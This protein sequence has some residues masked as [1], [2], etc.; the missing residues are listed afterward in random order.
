MH[1]TYR[2]KIAEIESLNDVMGAEGLEWK[3]QI[4]PGG[5]VNKNEAILGTSHGHG[6]TKTNIDVD[7]IQIA[8]ECT[9]NRTTT[10]CFA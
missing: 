2:V 5:P 1:S 7:L 3:D 6:I 10:L 8:V 4:V 9:I